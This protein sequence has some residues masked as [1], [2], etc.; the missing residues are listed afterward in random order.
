MKKIL[1]LFSLLTSIL[2]QVYGQSDSN[3]VYKKLKTK[4][5]YSVGLSSQ[6]VNRQVTYEVNGKK[7]N[8]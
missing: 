1:L 6:S 7:V 3:T 4:N 2:V 8:I 5:F